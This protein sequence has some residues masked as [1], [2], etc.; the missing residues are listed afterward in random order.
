MKGFRSN[1]L[2]RVLCFIA[3]ALFVLPIN[4][5]GLFAK[6]GP[7]V[8]SRVKHK[9]IKYFVPEKRIKV[10]AT[11]TDEQ[12]VNLVRCY[13]RAVEQAD[14][15]FV[16]MN[17]GSS[18]YQ[19]V[20]PAPS[21]DTETLEYLFLVVNGKNEVVKTQT[22]KVKKKDDDETPAWQQVSSKG[23]IH[24]TTELAQAPQVPPG[25]ADSIAVDIAESS[26]RFGVV[27]AG[28]YAAKRAGDRSGTTGEASEARDMGLIAAK[29]GG[30]STLAYVGIGAALI[31]GGA[32]A[33]GGG[34]GG[35]H[36]NGSGEPVDVGEATES[37]FVGR[38]NLRDPSRT[39]EQYHGTANL[40]Q[41]RT[42]TSIEVVDGS[43]RS[44]EG[45]WSY[46]QGTQ[47]FSLDWEPGGSFSG[48]VSGNTNNFTMS[49]TWSS[50]NPGQL[51]FSRY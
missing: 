12:G 15:V 27:V 37:D 36:H 29:T 6:E 3:A 40:S 21:K 4:G 44:G 28:I 24:V 47:T 23:D 5:V 50:G 34:G 18:L 11:V 14:Y 41:G 31:A 51:N 48:N 42:F 43:E 19:G 7:E 9:P 22:F 46:D 33:A 17:P 20:L 38:Y 8:T 26:A 45:V 10:E 35:G 13:F 2:G 39:Y 32:A 1:V 49:G 25:F 16:A 30:L